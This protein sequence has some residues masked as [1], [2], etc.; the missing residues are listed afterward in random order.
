MSIH[1]LKIFCRRFEQVFVNIA[2]TLYIDCYTQFR[3]NLMK[4]KQTAIRMPEDMKKAAQAK[5]KEQRRSFAGYILNL[6]AEDLGS[7]VQQ[8][9]EELE[10]SGQANLKAGKADLAK[11]TTSKKKPEYERKGTRKR[12][13]E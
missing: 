2:L 1:F 9:A 4:T 7:R 12:A 10:K 11:A 8:A 3:Q 13:R 6:M 5:A